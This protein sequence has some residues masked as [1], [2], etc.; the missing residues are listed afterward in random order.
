MANNIAVVRVLIPDTEEVFGDAGDET[1]FSDTDIEN[2]LLAGGG[3]ELRAAAFANYAIATSEALISK[4]IRTQ[5]LQTDGAKVAEALIKKGDALMKQADRED[6]AAD[7]GFYQII[8]Y[9]DGWTTYPPEL[10][11]PDVA[12]I[13][14]P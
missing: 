9:Q 11:E 2:Y 13:W 1:L 5:D 10:T 8:N 12:T 14:G 3:S 6:A 7:S 4:V